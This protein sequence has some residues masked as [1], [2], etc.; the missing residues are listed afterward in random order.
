MSDEIP[1]DLR[2]LVRLRGAYVIVDSYQGSHGVL[3]M[4]LNMVNPSERLP[5][6]GVGVVE[7]HVSPSSAEGRPSL[8]LQSDGMWEFCAP[9]LRVCA[10][11]FFVRRGGERIAWVVSPGAVL[12]DADLFVFPDS[13]DI[14][15]S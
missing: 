3:S 14:P 1:R 10:P 13:S 12:S 4:F 6:T 5:M 11:C 7:L 8:V 15:N 9:G 2:D